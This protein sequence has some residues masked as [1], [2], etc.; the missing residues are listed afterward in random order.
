[1][2]LKNEI[3]RAPWNV[4]L[5]IARM[6]LNLSQ[7]EAANKIGTTQKSIWMWETGKIIPRETSRRAISNAYGVNYEELFEGLIPKIQ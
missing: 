4:K 3:D 7:D 1:M 2:K 5:I 6:L